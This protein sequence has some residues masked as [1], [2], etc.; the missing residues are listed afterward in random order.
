MLSGGDPSALT[1]RGPTLLNIRQTKTLLRPPARWEMLHDKHGPNKRG[2]WLGRRFVVGWGFVHRLIR[3]EVFGLAVV[4][5]FE[6]VF[7]FVDLFLL[8][9][10][11]T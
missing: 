6:G 3:L 2:L 7:R 9:G 5:F 4:W 1:R 10:H 8:C 11:L